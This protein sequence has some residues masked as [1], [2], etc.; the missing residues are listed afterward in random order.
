[1]RSLVGCS[2]NATRQARLK[3]PGSQGMLPHPS[4]LRTVHESRPSHG[5]GPYCFL[6]RSLVGCVMTPPMHKHAVLLAIVT[7]LVF[8]RDVVSVDRIAVVER[9]F[10]EPTS[11]VL[12]VQPA[13][14]LRFAGQHLQAP[15]FP[16]CPV[17][18]QVRVHRRGLPG[19]LGASG[20]GGV[21]IPQAVRLLFGTDPVAVPNGTTI[22]L[23]DPL[24]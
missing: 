7:A 12:G 11:K 13:F 19:D 21:W 15:L 2:P 18:L 5:S 4:P 16:L 1:M 8:G 24:G 9:H 23:S 6:S 20:A 17:G 14:S 3:A 10:A 22:P